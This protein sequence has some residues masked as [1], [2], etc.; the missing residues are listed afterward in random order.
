M[1]GEL[2]IPFTTGILLGLGESSDDRIE[3][4]RVISEI[5][6]EF[7]HIQEVIFVIFLF[8]RIILFVCF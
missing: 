6:N 1:E 5:A 8:H 4:I 7:G 3:T 2:G